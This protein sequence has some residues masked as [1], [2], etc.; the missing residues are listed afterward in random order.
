METLVADFGAPCSASH[1]KMPMAWV[2][3]EISFRMIK[4]RVTANEKI[5]TTVLRNVLWSQNNNYYFH[6]FFLRPTALHRRNE[7][8]R[9][10]VALAGCRMPCVCVCVQS[11]VPLQLFR[12]NS[13][14]PA[15]LNGKSPPGRFVAPSSFAHG[16]PIQRACIGR[17][18][19]YSVKRK[20]VGAGLASVAA[21]ASSS[22]SSSWGR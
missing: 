15:E 20:T 4:F 3:S 21:A 16:A 9:V 12:H 1:S 10:Q 17:A 14:K 13:S 18:F 2:G 6:S 7:S 5:G 8:N 19:E 22:S 11:A